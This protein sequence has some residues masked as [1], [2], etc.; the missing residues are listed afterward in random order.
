MIKKVAGAFGKVL[1][2]AKGIFRT[3]FKFLSMFLLG[4][5]LMKTT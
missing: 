5:G 4:T 1:K 2:P 3:I